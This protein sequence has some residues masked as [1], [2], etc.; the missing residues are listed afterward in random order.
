[1]WLF[2]NTVPPREHQSCSKRFGELEERVQQ[3]ELTAVERNLQ[4]LDLCEKV[5][6]KLQDRIRHRM[7]K[8]EPENGGNPYDVIRYR[9]ASSGIP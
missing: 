6:E 7:K 9:R 4:V 1:M 3:L 8:A 2:R 5:A